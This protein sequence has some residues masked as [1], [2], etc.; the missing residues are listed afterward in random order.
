MSGALRDGRWL[1]PARL[2]AYGLA[3]AA[4]VLCILAGMGMRLAGLQG[5]PPGDIDFLSFHAAARLA[6]DGQAPAAWVQPAHAAA[7][8][9]AQG[10]PGGRYYAFFYPP[11]YLL[12]CLPFG[13]LPLVPAMAAWVAVTAAA[14]LAALRG[15]TAHRGWLPAML[16]LLAPASAL[17]AMHGQNAFLTT[18]LLALAGSMLDRRPALGG[19]ALATLAFKPQLGLLVIPALVAGRRWRALGWAVAVGCAWLVASWAAF[20]AEAWRAFL[21]RLPDAGAAL[22]SGD[23]ATWKV[24]SVYALARGLGAPE[25]MA[26]GAQAVVAAAVVALVCLA[27]RRTAEGRAQV[28][29]VAAGAALV[30]PFVLGYD[31]VILLI[32]TAWLVEQGRRGAF[33]PWEVTLLAFAWLFPWAG[34]AVGFAAGVSPGPLPA[35][36][37]FA[38]VLRRVLAA[39][40]RA[41]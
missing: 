6:L 2:R 12:V 22:A 10:V 16:V 35:A 39:P 32:P 7:Q 40:G 1:T 34:F 11:T 19:A 3:Y 23:L 37:V 9:A 18:A 30:T 26:K 17:N 20:G 4:L 5:A 21:V 41:P 31:L 14:C 33:L 28:A 13:L 38:L 36:I 29:L 24:Q 8:A 25:A 15:W 27:V